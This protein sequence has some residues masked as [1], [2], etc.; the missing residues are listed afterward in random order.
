[1]PRLL[2]R[3]EKGSVVF[4]Y[5]GEHFFSKPPYD[6]TVSVTRLA[7]DLAVQEYGY[8]PY[9]Q[10]FADMDSLVEYLNKLLASTAQITKTVLD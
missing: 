9:D 8:A 6:T 4:S 7:P 10:E 3:N 1:M 5:Y 2:A